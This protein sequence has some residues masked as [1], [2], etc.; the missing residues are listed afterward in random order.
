M[1]KAKKKTDTGIIGPFVRFYSFMDGEKSKRPKHRKAMVI[2]YERGRGNVVRP[3]EDEGMRRWMAMQEAEECGVIG[4]NLVSFEGYEGDG[5][6]YDGMDDDAVGRVDNLPDDEDLETADLIPLLRGWI[7]RPARPRKPLVCPITGLPARYKDPRTGVPYANKEAYQVIQ[8]I[9][10]HEFVWSGVLGAYVQDVGQEAPRGAPEGWKRAEVGKAEGEEDWPEGEG[11]DVP[12]WLREKRRMERE[13]KELKERER[14]KEKETK[15]SR[16][17]EEGHGSGK[18]G[19]EGDQDNS[20][21]EEAGKAE[22]SAGDGPNKK[23]IEGRESRRKG[24]RNS[25]TITVQE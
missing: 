15:R 20:K 5:G 8:R 9:A 4:R 21:R 23:V 25:V 19:G 16:G 13:S 7:E 18:K 22:G 3:I 2:E 1:Q 10:R 11:E 12:A 14:I 6:G 17:E 24:L